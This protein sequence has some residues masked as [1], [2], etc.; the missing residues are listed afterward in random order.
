MI[1]ETEK[2]PATSII[3]HNTDLEVMKN[4]C[5]SVPYFSGLSEE[6]TSIFTILMY[7]SSSKWPTSLNSILGHPTDKMPSQLK[8][9]KAYKRSCQEENCSLSLTGES[10][11]CLENK[12]HNTQ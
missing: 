7:K 9:N 8:E 5:I 10:T 4:A 2:I 11:R 6:F 1:K 12:T 3:N